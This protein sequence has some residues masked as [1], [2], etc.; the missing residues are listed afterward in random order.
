MTAFEDGKMA[1]PFSP[2]GPNNLA[3]CSPPVI[4]AIMGVPQDKDSRVAKAKTLQHQRC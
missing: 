4:F 2:S 3:P 1:T